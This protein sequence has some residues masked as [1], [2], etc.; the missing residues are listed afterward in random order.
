M[1]YRLFFDGLFVILADNESDADEDSY[2]E[3][4]GNAEN[5]EHVLNEAREQVA[6]S[7]DARNGESVR[8]LRRN[9][10]NVV[11]LRAR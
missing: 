10:V 4:R 1:G 3:N 11:A 2:H 9:V 8:Q 7:R 6:D 5:Y